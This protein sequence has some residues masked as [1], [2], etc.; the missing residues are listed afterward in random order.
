[1]ASLN[2]H[3][4]EAIANADAHTNNACL[5]SYSDLA[6]AI[7]DIAEFASHSRREY[8]GTKKWTSTPTSSCMTMRVPTAL[9]NRIRDAGAS[10]GYTETGA[11]PNDHASEPA[12]GE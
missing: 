5:P 3:Q 4:I 10:V 1:M 8:G 6:T 7:R 11:E 9:L 12:S 2:T